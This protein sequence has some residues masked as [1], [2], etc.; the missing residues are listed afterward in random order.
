MTGIL[1][2]EVIRMQTYTEGKPCKVT[3]KR[4]PSASQREASEE[5]N[6]TESLILDI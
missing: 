3:V 5:T 4:L 6:P 2:E 1:L